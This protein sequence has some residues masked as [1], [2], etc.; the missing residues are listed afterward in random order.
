MDY[1]H[2]SLSLQEISA[3]FARKEAFWLSLAAFARQEH[4]PYTRLNYLKRRLLK[5]STT[6]SQETSPSPVQPFLQLFPSPSIKQG[7]S[8]TLTLSCSS[9]VL[10]IPQHTDLRFLT[11]V[12]EVLKSHV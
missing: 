2:K 1:K 3:L 4:I 10:Q 6:A 5:A 7:S 9:F 8:Q 12:L 11:Q